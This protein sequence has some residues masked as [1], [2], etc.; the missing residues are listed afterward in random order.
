MKAGLTFACMNL[1][2]L[3]KILDAR[4]RQG[5][6]SGFCFILTKKYGNLYFYKKNGAGAK[7]RHQLCLQSE[8][9]QSVIY[10][11]CTPCLHM[12]LY[13]MYPIKVIFLIHTPSLD[14]RCF[15]SSRTSTA[16]SKY[17]P[18]II[19]VQISD[20]S[21]IV[22]PEN[23]MSSYRCSMPQPNSADFIFFLVM[24]LLYAQ[25][26]STAIFNCADIP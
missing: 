5:K 13:I 20:Q 12:A 15:S 18:L 4:E 26:L 23:Q 6:N 3:A 14:T 21:T 25:N 19:K 16:S 24:L 10:S 22:A 1:K 11:D 8:G 9:V 17:H 7:L 2:K